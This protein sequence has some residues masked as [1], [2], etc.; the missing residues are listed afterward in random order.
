[1]TNKLNVWY[2]EGLRFTCTGCGACCTG[3]PGYTWVSEEEI[4]AI[5]KFLNVSLEEMGNRYIRKV[6]NHFSLR[7]NPKNFDCTFLE[8]KQCKIYPVRPH[9]CR[10]F[11]WWPGNL[12]SEEKWKEAAKGCEGIC[13]T[14]ELHSREK[15]DETVHSQTL[16]QNGLHKS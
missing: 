6:G 1:M 12:A 14:G 7:E 2:E 16:Y 9:Q 8:G 15:I 10:T 5:A 13:N 11:P 3:A 4:V